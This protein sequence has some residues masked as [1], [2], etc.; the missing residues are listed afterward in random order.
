MLKWISLLA[1]T[2]CVTPPCW[3]Q[4]ATLALTHDH[5]TGI[6]S[7]AETITLT[8][9]LSWTGAWQAARVAGDAVSTPDIGTAFGNGS[10]GSVSIGPLVTFGTPVAGSVRGVDMG[11]G[12]NFFGILSPWEVSPLSMMRYSWTAPATPGLV[13]F[14]F[15]PHPDVPDALFYIQPLST[16]R[17]PL[18]TTYL[19]TSITVIP[20][21]ASVITS[22]LAG[23]AMGTGRR[24][25]DSL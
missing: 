11:S 9:T 14:D 5:P 6:V 10:T 13:E 4:S 19:G 12:P 25:R 16:I 18:P 20:A 15:T 2:G 21:P 24:R 3:A 23:L 22:A 17:S 1:V 8:L 7:P